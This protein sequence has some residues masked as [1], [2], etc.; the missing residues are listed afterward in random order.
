MSEQSLPVSDALARVIERQ[1]D[2]IQRLRAEL[3]ASETELN[4]LIGLVLAAS[5]LTDGVERV[6]Y[7]RTKREVTYGYSVAQSPDI[8]REPSQ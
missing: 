4:E 2:S 6:N 1:I 8:P 5:N 3:C 7:S